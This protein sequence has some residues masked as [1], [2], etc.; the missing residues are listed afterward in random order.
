MKELKSIL[1]NVY[2]LRSEWSDCCTS[3]VETL[4]KAS[5]VIKLEQNHN[6]YHRHHHQHQSNHILTILKLIILTIIVII[7]QHI[8]A[9]AECGTFCQH[10]DACTESTAN[11]HANSIKGKQ[12]KHYSDLDDLQP[13]IKQWWFMY[14]V[15]HAIL[16]AVLYQRCFWICISNKQLVWKATR[17]RV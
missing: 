6:H 7:P 9:H 17:Y 3:L 5:K 4:V 14:N 2:S 8:N 16:A 10:F 1:I 13:G 11:C 12:M 15:I